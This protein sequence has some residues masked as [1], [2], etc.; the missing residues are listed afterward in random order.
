MTGLNQTATHLASRATTRLHQ[1]FRPATMASYSRKFR[2]FVAFCSFINVHL[3]N[4]TPLILLAFLEFLVVNQTSPSNIANYMS[5]VKTTLAMHGVSTIA[6]HDQRI[7]LFQKSLRMTRQFAVK[8]KKIIDIDMLKHIV[9]ICDTM[10]MG[11]IFKAL[12]LVA[13]FSFLRISNLVPHKIAAFSPLQQ[14]TRGDVFFAS[15]GLHILVKWTKTMQTRDSVKILKLPLLS[16]SP[17][18][19]V[20][21]VKNLLMLTPGHQDTPLFQIKNAKAQWVPLTDSQT[22]RNFIQILTRLGL[23]DSGMSLHTFRRSGASLAF[24]S[25]VALQNIQSHGTWTS[26]CVW[27]YIVQD[28]NAS[29]QVADAFQAL[30]AGTTS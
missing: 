1:A 30:L 26:D 17:L 9:G 22:R 7:M 3:H 24:N 19:P 20:T 16:H 14:L 6:F 12:Y 23:Q 21:A 2:L 5:A 28:H 25:N 15:P 4:L 13:F 18:C 10:W 8:I 27:R 29:Q 11:Q